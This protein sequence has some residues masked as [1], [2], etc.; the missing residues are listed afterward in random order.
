M[1]D[2]TFKNVWKI[3]APIDPVWDAIAACERWPQWWPYL[4]SVDKIAEGEPCG[5]GSVHRFHWGGPL[6]YRLSFRMTVTRIDRPRLIEGVAE[7]DLEGFGSWLLSDEGDGTTRVE[8]TMTARATKR[9][10]RLSAPLLEWFF[11]WNHNRVM[12]AG[13]EGLADCLLRV[14]RRTLLDGE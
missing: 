4:E 14:E 3:D 5:L 11:T 9:W 1:G 10:M 12:D 6:P 13:R 2:Y 8:Y 7:G